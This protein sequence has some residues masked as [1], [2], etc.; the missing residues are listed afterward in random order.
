[1]KLIA[2][3]FCSLSF[4]FAVAQTNITWTNPIAENA[5]HVNYDPNDYSS[6]QPITDHYQILCDLQNRIS[7]DSLK[8]HLEHLVSF[9]TRN[10]Y[11]DTVSNTTGVGAARRWAMAKFNQFSSENDNRLLTSYLSFDRIGMTCGDFYDLRNVMAVLPG[12]DTSE[13]SIIVIEA[14]MDSRCEDGC[15]SASICPGA[16]DNGSGTSLVIELART[17]SKYTFRRTIMFMLTV[18]E[19]QGLLGADAMADYCA[20]NGVLI[21][22]VQNNDVIGGIICGNTSSAPSCPGLNHIDSTQIRLFSI[23]TTGAQHRNFTRTIKLWYEE[24][25]GGVVTVPT[26]IS[27]MNQEDRSGRGGDHQPFRQR[28]YRNCRFTAANEHGDAG[29]GP[30]YIDRQHTG[31][32]ILGVDTDADLIIDSFYVDFN[33]LKRNTMINAMS[34]VLSANGP[35]YPLFQLLDEPTGLRVKLL[36]HFNMPEYR[37]AVRLPG[38]ID[39]DFIYRTTDTSFIVPGLD[40]ATSYA[41]SVAAINS[42]GIMGNFSGEIIQNS[43]VA[44]APGTP[45]PLPYG[46]PCSIV[47]I[48][49]SSSIQSLEISLLAPRPNP[50]QETTTISVF[51]ELSEIIQG[52]I[53]IRDIQGR[54]LDD[55]NLELNKGNNLVPYSPF[56][57]SNGIYFCNLFVDG[58]LIGSQK[59]IRSSN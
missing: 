48:E 52:R 33:Y 2:I 35:D 27:I 31:N 7:A 55:F 50:F 30:G 45:D 51:S 43:D 44:T 37:V 6:A 25:M 53:E 29:V 18:G 40:S 22:Q 5:V 16:E 46:T 4:S 19:E 26:T 9:G 8:D 1:M 57:M 56:R 39:W 3:L 10:T 36:S 24:T 54:I 15:D 12:S 17:M 21:K 58:K 59:I 41:I 23:G 42:N 14:H 20:N 47:G 34:A 32:D 11:S 13:K 49:E 28:G 38:N